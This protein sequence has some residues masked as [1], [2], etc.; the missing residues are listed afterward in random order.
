MSRVDGIR[1]QRVRVKRLTTALQEEV[2]DSINETIDQVHAAGL[3]NLDAMVTRRT[4]RLRRY[5]RKAFRRGTLE[6]LVGYISAKG[7]D[8]AFYARFVHD[9]TEEMAARPWHDTAIEEVA[10][11]HAQRMR[12]ASPSELARTGGGRARRVR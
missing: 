1:A 2:A 3:A 10:P 5:Y 8:A 7:R 12:R 11:D 4:G 9:G 6:G